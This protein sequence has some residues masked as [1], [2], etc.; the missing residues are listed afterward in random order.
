MGIPQTI[1]IVLFTYG[2]VVS[3]H[4]REGKNIELLSV[5]HEALQE[6]SVDQKAITGIAVLVG[7]GTF[8]STRLAVTVANTFA[9][10]NQIPVVT[11]TVAQKDNF[12]GMEDM[13]AAATPGQFISATYS[14]DP[15][16]GKK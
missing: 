12:A 5:L 4:V 2:G 1:R 15:R 8:T 13:L 16:I 10:A 3:E 9:Y 14:G 7:V 6:S 11:V